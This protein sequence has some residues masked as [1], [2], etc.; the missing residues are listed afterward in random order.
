MD[1]NHRIHINLTNYNQRNKAGVSDYN[2]AFLAKLRVVV[3]AVLL[4]V[5]YLL[6][7]INTAAARC[8]YSIFD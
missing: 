4:T 8:L 2:A 1:D 6:S 5:Y 7:S 3:L